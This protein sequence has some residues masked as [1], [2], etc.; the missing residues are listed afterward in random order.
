M[1]IILVVLTTFLCG[2]AI[3]KTPWPKDAKAAYIARC[4]ESMST[5]GLPKQ[6][7]SSYCSC[8]TD[9][10]EKEFGM[11]E[12]KEMMAAQPNPRGSSHDRR[13]HTVMSACEGDLRK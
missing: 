5:Q 11:E 4:S 3:A 7:A 10:M 1:R 2:I 6:K 13:L 12:Y 9:G 8:V